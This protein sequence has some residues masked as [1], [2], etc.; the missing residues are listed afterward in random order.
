MNGV[1]RSVARGLDTLDY[2][3][4]GDLVGTFNPIFYADMD[5]QSCGKKVMGREVTPYH[6]SRFPERKAGHDPVLSE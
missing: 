2:P 5:S 6:G 1:L 3:E 4:E